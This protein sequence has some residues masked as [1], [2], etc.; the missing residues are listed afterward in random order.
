MSVRPSPASTA[1]CRSRLL[2][3]LQGAEE[4]HFHLVGMP[5]VDYPRWV[6]AYRE[7][8]GI[9]GTDRCLVVKGKRNGNCGGATSVSG[10][11]RQ[12]A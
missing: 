3:A 9:C 10:E 11:N 8:E 7:Y 1:P 2:A 5:Y 4:I 12:D 6:V